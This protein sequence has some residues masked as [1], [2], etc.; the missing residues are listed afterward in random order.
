MTVVYK[1]AVIDASFVKTGQVFDG[2]GGYRPYSGTVSRRFTTATESTDSVKSPNYWRKSVQMVKFEPRSGRYPTYPRMPTFFEPPKPRLRDRRPNQTGASWARALT[3]HKVR[4][5]T[6][7][8]NLQRKRSLYDSR[9]AKYRVRLAKYNAF[10]RK[11]AE[12]VPRK[13]RVRTNVVTQ[14]NPYTYTVTHDSGA[15]GTWRLHWRQWFYGKEITGSYAHVGNIADYVYNGAWPPSPLTEVK[16]KVASSAESLA[17]NRFHEKLTGELVHLGQVIAERAQTIGL[18]GDAVKRL[19][20]FLLSFRVK[21]IF[22][23]LKNL[24]KS[25]NAK[26]VANDYLAFQ[27]GVLPL[28]SDVKGSAEAVAHFVVDNINQP[29]VRIASEAEKSEEETKI[30]YHNSKPYVFTTRVTV[31]IRYVCEYELDNVVTREMSKLGVFNPAEIIW[32]LVPWSF[33]VDWVLPIGNYL[34]HLTNDTG[35]VFKRGSRTTTVTEQIVSKLAYTEKDPRTIPKYWDSEN[36]NSWDISQTKTSKTKTRTILS[37]PPKVAFP[38]F[39]NPLSNTHVFESLA[40][41]YQQRFK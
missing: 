40:L 30:V 10:A 22:R 34:R 31:K 23:T 38:N 1:S 28:I 13:V 17:L 20:Q 18:L 25:V 8:I 41:L 3:R 4:L 24:C 16:A 36:W 2:Q 5:A 7:E 14:W 9:L 35:L 26:N 32:E 15:R 39:K 33:V 12:G 19:A 29:F 21:G 27:F 37:T 6:F 11:M